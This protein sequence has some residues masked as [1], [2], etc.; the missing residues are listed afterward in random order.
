M[1]MQDFAVRARGGLGSVWI[2]AG[3]NGGREQDD[4]NYDGYANHP[5]TLAVGAI[6]DAGRQSSYSEP[7]A[8]L[9][10]SAPSSGGSRGITTT[11]LLGSNGY[12]STDCTDSF[13]GTS[14]AAP[15]V[16]GVVGLV[17]SA[18]PKLS[19]KDVQYIMMNTAIKVDPNDTDWVRNGAG[20]WVSHR[21]GYGM[22]DANAS[23]TMALNYGPSPRFPSKV[24]RLDSGLMSPMKLLS[25]SGDYTTVKT[26]VNQSDLSVEHVQV[27]LT[28]RHPDV[29]HLDIWLTSPAGTRSRLSSLRKFTRQ[30]SIRVIRNNTFTPLNSA[31]IAD[32]SPVSSKE[33]IGLAAK[34][35][36]SDPYG[37][38]TLDPALVSG[39]VWVVQR[40]ECFFQQKARLAQQAGAVGVVVVALQGQQ[41]VVMGGDGGTDITIPTVMVS[42]DDGQV[43][44]VDGVSIR[45]AEIVQKEVVSLQMN[46]WKFSSVRHWDEMA[47]GEWSLDVRDGYPSNIGTWGTVNSP[48]IA[49]W[50]LIV[51]HSKDLGDDSTTSTTTT[52]STPVEQVLPL[53]AK[54]LVAGVGGAVLVGGLVFLG[55]TLWRKRREN[56]DGNAHGQLQASPLPT[57]DD[58][59]E[60]DLEED[61][62]DLL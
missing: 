9:V 59:F 62:G 20:R 14:S 56:Q 40:G 34:A 54:A 27:E 44:Q 24:R 60:I 42:W 11:D 5:L 57:N 8:A 6:S 12:S 46:A 3:G 50:R 26:F 29:T 55:I 25:I 61:D 53:W 16:A 31:V 32:F 23:V 18:N 1:A 28:M 39:R 41:P 47:Y 19:W 2:W 33:V 13:G 15:L 58:L 4:C 52:S 21:Y 36:A 30:P 49:S 43:A 48:A 37:C 35:P 51:W 38:S 7:C 22:V 17:L 45:L 10:V